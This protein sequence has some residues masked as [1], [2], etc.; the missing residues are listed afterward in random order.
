MA[1]ARAETGVLAEILF[2]G[3]CL[4]CGRW[5]LLA[6]SGGLPICAE[7]RDALVPLSGERCRQCSM[8]LTG[9]RDLCSRCRTAGYL[10]ECNHS[11]FAYAGP[12]RELIAAYKFGGR[13]RLARLFA[14]LLSQAV[15]GCFPGRTVIPVPP[16]P[17]RRGPDAV[18]RIARM[19]QQDHGLSVC[20]CLARTGGVEQ[21]SLD[22]ASR[23]E[24]LRGRISVRSDVGP[25]GIPRAAV[26]LD[27][28]FTTGA[29]ADACA[30]VLVAAGC[31]DVAVVTLAID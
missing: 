2:P 1:A 7:C 19:L 25:K 20:R 27:D 8:P 30:R 9:E 5:L 11:V 10:F 22:F 26:L 16:R 17:R 6:G 18:E 13:T 21:K 14:P 28:V 3:R 12:V 15:R 23:R 31:S 4:L 29:T 24:N